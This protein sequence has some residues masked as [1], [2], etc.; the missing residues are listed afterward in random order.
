[1][2]YALPGGTYT[3]VLN[4]GVTGLVGTLK[5]QL[6]NAD[7]TTAVGA[8]IAG[9]VEVEPT[10]YA[11]DDNVA[12][13]KAG[14]YIVVWNNAGERASEELIVTADLPEPGGGPSFPGYPTTAELVEASDN[15]H[16]EAL[17]G[18]QQD[19]L[20]TTAITMIE[21]YAGQKF[22]AEGTEGA[23]VTRVLSGTGATEL[24]LPQRLEQLVTLTV[25][26]GSLTAADCEL[27]EEHDHLYIAPTSTSTWVERALRDTRE[28]VFPRQQRNNIKVAGV[29][30]WAVCPD[31]VVQAIRFDMEDAASAGSAEFA[32][33]LQAWR[34]LGM[35]S[36]NQGPLSIQLEDRPLILSPRAADML[37]AAGLVW[38]SIGGVV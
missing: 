19:G 33:S 22:I 25:V 14:T 27:A 17:T 8:T 32:P 1:M 9:I 37:D 13:D 11:K 6:E 36:M 34:K 20:R 2:I 10:I 38:G 21:A 28:L 4:A 5:I 35:S 30:G 15:D 29:W 23:P 3:A 31:T 26:D 7:G 24:Y 16:L 12:P 18:V